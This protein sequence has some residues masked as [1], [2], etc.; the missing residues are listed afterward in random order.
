MTNITC[1]L[2]ITIPSTVVVTWFH[3]TTIPLDRSQITTADNTATLLIG[4]LQPSDAGDYQCVFNDVLGSGWTIRRNL[5][6]VI[7]GMLH[8]IQQCVALIVAISCTNNTL[9]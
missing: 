2:N 9:H 6:L 3:N 1:S 4:D 5:R 8:I 7:A